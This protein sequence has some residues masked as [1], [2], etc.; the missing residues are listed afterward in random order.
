MVSASPVDRERMFIIS[1]HLSDDTLSVYERTHRNLGVIGGKFL[2]RGRVKTPGQELFK[3][4]LSE[5]YGAQDLYVGARLCLNAHEFQLTDADEFT[6]SYMEQNA[7]EVRYK[8][9]GLTCRRLL[10]EADCQLSE[11]EIL[12]LGRRYSAAEPQRSDLG[13][14][15]AAAAQ[16]R[17]K[18]SQYESFTDMTKAFMHEDRARAGWLASTEARIICKAFRIPLPD[19]LLMALFK[20]FENEAGEIDYHSFL[21][22]INWRVNPLPPVLHDD[23]IKFDVDWSGE[24]N[25]ALKDINYSILLEEAFGEQE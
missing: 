19:S 2:E 24:V 13:L 1:Y 21:A 20:Q 10:E 11:H 6:L 5:C 17:L 8:V 7:E 18:K 16:E 22:R 4:D 9:P 25:A 23:V 12:A 15:L 3:S 14:L